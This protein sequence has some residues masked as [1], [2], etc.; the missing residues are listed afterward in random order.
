M[1][2][3]ANLEQRYKIEREF[4]DHW[5]KTIK[6]EQ[7]NF[8]GAF[9]SVTAVENR[10]ALSQMA[11]IKGK[12]ILDLGCG[13]G[14]ASLYFAS[15]G[16][17]VYSVDISPEMIRLVKR[18]SQ[19]NNIGGKIIAKVMVAE[20]LK[21]PNNYFD[22]VYGNGVLHHVEIDKA[23]Q[24]VYRVL[25]KGG[26]A[27]FTEPLEHN[28]VINI[29]RRMADRV[30][31]TTESP[32]KYHRLN[33]LTKARFRKVFHHEFHFFTLGIFL[34]Y[35]VVEGVNPNKERYWK[36]IINDGKRIAKP[37]SFLHS[38]DQII[39]KQVSFLRKFFWNT[40][41]VFIK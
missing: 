28:P 26:V 30:R 10:F 31:T 35:F 29:Y 37:F 1:S 18:I 13:M 20:K 24:E 27:V 32:L 21:F 2:K 17:K 15:R 23:L 6:P 8:R 14:D 12:K 11:E 7:V 39:V 19:K 40:V 33:K 3:R 22:F 38:L 16:A 41:I 25:K 9:E 34:W 5:A 36:K 4:H